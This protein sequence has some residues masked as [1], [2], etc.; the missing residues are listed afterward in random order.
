MIN[1]RR[2]LILNLIGYAALFAVNAIHVPW[3]SQG[4]EAKR[5]L[6]ARETTYPIVAAQM[7]VM[8]FL[9]GLYFLALLHWEKLRFSVRTIVI[10]AMASGLAAWCSVPGV[11]S[12][13]PWVYLQFGRIAGVHGMNPY[14]HAYPE[15]HDA[16]SP[17]AWL[18]LPMSYGPVVLLA[19]IPAAWVSTVNVLLAIYFVKLEWLAAY[20]ASIWLLLRILQSISSR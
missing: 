11:N 8:L 18:P 1:G 9:F 4:E 16:Y 5:L 20:A 6:F 15:V 7:A 12:A 10:I 3:T 17:Y 13:D 14:L 2:F 19:L